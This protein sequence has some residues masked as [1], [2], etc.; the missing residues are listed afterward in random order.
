MPRRTD[1]R[2]AGRRTVTIALG[3]IVAIG[4]M[5]RFWGLDFGLPHTNTRPDETMVIDVALEFLR[6]NFRP[7]FYDYPWLYMWS[8][9]GLYLV[10]FVWGAATG[11]FQSVADLAAS[12]RMHWVPFFM[13]NRALSAA[14]GTLTI[15][16]VFRIAR[17]LWDDA[18]AVVAALFMSLTFLH[19]RDS[20]YGTTDT[21]MTFLLMLSVAFLV[22]AHQRERRRDF[23]VAGFVGGLAAATK[24]NALLV[25]V[26]IA[27]SYLL[28][29][30][31]S[32]DR[33]RAMLD[34]RLLLFAI[35]FLAALAIGAP[36]LFL[37]S[38]KFLGQMRLLGGTMQGAGGYGA[39]L[40]HGWIHHLQYSLRYGMGLPLLAAGLAGTIV[41]FVREPRAAVLLM[42]FPIAYYAAA[43]SVR[44]LFFRYAIP[45]VPFLCLAAARLI[46]RSVP[47]MLSLAAAGLG[48]PAIATGRVRAIA[49]A[50]AATGVVLPSAL[51]TFR[52]DRIISR[53]DNRVVIARWFEANV[54][55]GSSV[56]MSGSVY[57]Y[58]QFAR[59]MGY[60]VWDWDR[61]HRVFVIGREKSPAVGRPEWILVQDSPLPS[62]TQ[63]IVLEFLEE[64]YALT[65]HFPA[66]S[67]REWSV[68]DSQDAFFVPFAGFRGVERP[69]PNYSLYKRVSVP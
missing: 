35:P 27:A 55:P 65:R 4:A 25:V 30:I 60:K 68:Y 21:M 66:F 36:F 32:A 43:G 8:I 39:G 44:L 45:V 28:K 2:A 41:L 67:A 42:S 14:L 38:D 7:V 48:R 24:Y 11:V 33:R 5:A 63:P 53:T 31:D 19:V 26:P 52:F 34:P 69:G 56:L 62:A 17:R 6:G 54:P 61:R 57:G 16:V 29:L 49:I 12:W 15:V 18:T 50:I 46:T 51:S 47:G 22:E 9:T 59:E 20:H 64:G 1:P 37:D 40:G 10:Y 13:I 3:A 58:V 23:V